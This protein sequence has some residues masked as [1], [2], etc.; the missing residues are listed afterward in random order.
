MK[1]SILSLAILASTM[2]FMGCAEDAMDGGTLP[3]SA[4]TITVH[5]T[6]AEHGSRAAYTPHE[7]NGVLNLDFSWE[8]ADKLSLFAANNNSGTLSCSKVNSPNDAT[9]TGQFSQALTN[10]T[11]VYGCV[12]FDGITADNGSITA[13]LSK[14]DGTLADATK[15]TIIYGKGTY[16]PSSAEEP[17]NIKFAQ[18][19][20]IIKFVL[21]FPAEETGNQASVTIHADGLY[22]RVALNTENGDENSKND[23]DITIAKATVADHQAEVYISVYPSQ[24]KEITAYATIGGNTYTYTSRPSTTIEANKVYRITRTMLP[25]AKTWDFTTMSDADK[26]AFE[27]NIAKGGEWTVDGNWWYNLKAVGQN[28]KDVVAYEDIYQ[29]NAT[30]PLYTDIQTKAEAEYTKGLHFGVWIGGDE[31]TPAK[32]KAIYKNLKIQS[33]KNRIY[34]AGANFIIVIP[35]LKAG[36]MVEV[37]MA[38]NSKD[39]SRYLASMNLKPA[40]KGQEANYDMKFLRKAKVVKD[41]NVVLRSTGGVYVYDITVKDKY[42]NVKSKEDIAK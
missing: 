40:F 42:G 14:Q 16:T 5:A 34:L 13:D 28:S 39:E 25:E 32:T 30:K 2:S 7:E 11:N 19:M 26:T 41:G 4:Q 3:S 8:Q 38:G 29:L 1:Q 9:F 6:T 23:G 18:K 21:T 24:M 35:S 22:N 15:H 27:A 31:T 10:N 36:D 20:A 33:D 12:Q 17:L 37:T